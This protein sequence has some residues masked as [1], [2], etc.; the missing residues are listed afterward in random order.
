M[1]D[2]RGYLKEIDELTKEINRLGE[3]KK[4]LSKRKREVENR[5][6]VFLEKEKQIGVKHQGTAV[7]AKEKVVRPRRNKKDRKLAGEEVLRKY[8]IRD[9]ARVFDELD[10]ALKGSPK[11]SKELKI[12]N[13][14]NRRR[15]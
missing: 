6:L 14:D 9:V 5:I 7:I 2:I 4:A 3:R 15:R 1:G 11:Q 10:L 12:Q 13:Y 8:G